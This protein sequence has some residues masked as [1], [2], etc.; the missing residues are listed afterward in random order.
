MKKPFLTV[1]LTPELLDL[2]VAQAKRRGVPKST[3]AEAAI[4]SFLTPDTA[5]QQEAALGR[6]LDRLNRHADRLERDLEI[7]VEM[8]ALFVRTWMAATPSL[9]DAVQTAARA[10]GRDR[11]ERFVENLGRRLASGRS[12]TRELALELEA[13]TR[14]DVVD[15]AS[16]VSRNDIGDARDEN[17]PS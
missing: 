5:Q 16:D 13:A 14:D 4:A 11:Y 7:A 3:V 10:R 6:R 12:F 2:L 17:P 1:Y 8:L 15:R 9:P